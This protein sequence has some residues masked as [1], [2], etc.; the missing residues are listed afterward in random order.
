MSCRPR[1][2]ALTRL[3]HGYAVGLVLAVLAGLAVLAAPAAQAG[4][5][6]SRVGLGA[7]GGPVT[8]APAVDRMPSVGLLYELEPNGAMRVTETINYTFDTTQGT[9]RGIFRDIV[10]NQGVDGRPEVYRHYA[11]TDVSVSSPS[12][13]SADFTKTERGDS[14]RL[15]IGSANRTVSGTQTYVIRYRLANV[16]NPFNDTQTAELY[17]NVFKGDAIPKARVTLEVDAPVAANEVRCGRGPAGDPCETATAGSPSAFAVNDLGA[18][19]DLTVALRYPLSAFLGIAPDLR[20]GSGS[21]GLLDEGLARA[22]SIAA[23]A[24]GVGAP[25][26]AL[27]TMG[28]LVATRGRDEWY[29]GLTPGLT[30]GAVE[31]QQGAVATRRGGTPPVT[32]Q[33]NPPPGVQPGLVGTIIDESAD[34]VDVSATVIDL[35]VRGFLVIEEVEGNGIFKRTDWRLTQLVPRE[36]EYLRPYEQ[37]LLNG[38]FSR[39]NPVLLSELKNHFAKTL[40]SVKD[41]MYDEVLQR[42]WFRKSPER[43]RGAWQM[44]G[45][46][47]SGAGVA[48]LFFGG[49]ASGAIDR[50]AGFGFPVPSGIVLGIG[51]VV[52]GVIVTILGHRMA[53]KTGEG[54]AVLAQS[55]GFRQYLETAEAGQ[56]RWEEA[57]SIFSR[58]LPFAIVFGVAE[59]WAQ[60]FQQVAAAAAAAGHVVVMPDWYIY[61]GSAMPD[62]G[63]ITS[64]VDSFS[65]NAAGTFASTPGSSGSSGFGSSGGSFSGGGG[66]GSSSGSW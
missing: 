41:Q 17:W 52:A 28:Y 62:F 11:M 53:A 57:Q 61:H 10:V 27:G 32:V 37:A 33:F 23:L 22:M 3:L 9:R 24:G 65:T 44:L 45:F 18:R 49:T 34:T 48:S 30:P 14:I 5:I 6:P 64:G 36:G 66:G 31:R 19:E 16:M 60:T 40:T 39:G 50:S 63:S 58:Y 4:G 13:A 20:Q 35:A 47:V 59:R 25:L 51:L 21:G 55:L 1:R 29:A 8:A 15:Q 56:I 7:W 54:S 12:G 38:L 43:Q 42:G 46:L 2:G 26:L